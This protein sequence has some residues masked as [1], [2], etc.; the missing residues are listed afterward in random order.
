MVTGTNVGTNVD[1]VEHMDTLLY[2]EGGIHFDF[3]ILFIAW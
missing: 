3:A 1:Q 2:F